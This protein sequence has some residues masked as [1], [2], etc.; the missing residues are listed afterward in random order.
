MKSFI[1]KTTCLLFIVLVITSCSKKEECDPEDE[2]SP[3]YAGLSGNGKG[4]ISECSYK[5]KIDGQETL[6]NQ[7]GK[8]KIAITSGSED[9]VFGFA[10]YQKKTDPTKESAV[11][12]FAH[13]G[14]F[15]SKL[16]VG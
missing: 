1:Q 14:P 13:G 9:G 8:D 10:I 16:P 5:V 4:S 11:T 7:F 12:A 3:C 15:N 6:P 2:E